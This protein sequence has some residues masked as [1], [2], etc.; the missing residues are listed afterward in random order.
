MTKNI[1]KLY[2]LSTNYYYNHKV[3]NCNSASP[4]RLFKDSSVHRLVFDGSFLIVGSKKYRSNVR[5]KKK[6]QLRSRSLLVSPRHR[7]E[8]RSIAS[9]MHCFH[10]FFSLT[11]FLPLPSL[12][13]S[14]LERQWLGFGVYNDIGIG[15]YVL[16]I[17]ISVHV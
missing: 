1:R 8:V 17:Y 16:Y 4:K 6:N 9:R 5:K 12:L 2:L 13:S 14:A 15:G 11:L 10:L 3:D 7:V